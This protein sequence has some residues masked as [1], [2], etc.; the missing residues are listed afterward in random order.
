M[1][2]MLRRAGAML[3]S[4][5]VLSAVAGAGRAAEPSAKKPEPTTGKPNGGKAQ[6]TPDFSATTLALLRDSLASLDKGLPAGS[7]LRME[8][9]DKRLADRVAAAAPSSED[10]AAVQAEVARL[11]VRALGVDE[12]VYAV[13]PR[14]GTVHWYESFGYYCDSQ[15]PV[16]PETGG[17]LV[18]LDLRTGQTKEILAD[19]QGIFRDPCVSYD[20]SKILFSYRPAGRG[21]FHL[22]EANADGTG[23]RQLTDG[24]YDDIEPTYLPD[25]GIMFCS[26]RCRR[27]VPCLNAPVAILYRCDGDGRDIQP[28]SANVETENS[29]WPMPDGRIIYM[30]WEYVDRSRVTFHNL[31]TVNPDGTQHMVYWGN[32]GQPDVMNDPK[33]IPGTDQVICIA[34]NHAGA[35]HAGGVLI[36]DALGGPDAYSSL[37]FIPVPYQKL[38]QGHPLYRDPYPLSRDVFLVAVGDRVVVMDDTGRELVMERLPA[39]APASR[40]RQLW[41]HEPRPLAPRAREP[42]LA[43]RAQDRGATG[44]FL[45]VNVLQGRNMRGVRPGEIRMLLVLEVLPK[46]TD[47]DGHTEPL[48]HTGTF[49]LERI[50]GMVPVEPDGSAYFEA[51]AMR[52]L[53]F[54]ALDERGLSVQRMMS[55]TSLMPGETMSCVGCHEPR[56]R[57]SSGGPPPMALSKPPAQIQPIAGVPQIFDFGRDIQPV[58]NRHCV[59]CHNDEKRA[60]DLVLNDDHTIAFNQA[61]LMLRARKLFIDGNDG[62]NSGLPPRAVGSSASRILTMIDGSH[63]GVKLT[64]REQQWMRLWIDSACLYA[65]TYAALNTTPGYADCWGPDQVD[66]IVIKSRCA[67]CHKDGLMPPKWSPGLVDHREG[68]GA[69]FNLS[70]PERSLMLRAPLAKSAG[71]LGLCK[72]RVAVKYGDVAWGWKPDDFPQKLTKLKEG[73][74]ADVFQDT[75]D[76][77][78]QKLLADIRKLKAAIEP[79]RYD[80]PGFKGTARYVRE[81]KRHGVLP[82][83]FDPAKDPV[84][85]YET[86]ERYFRSFWYRAPD[87]AAAKEEHR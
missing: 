61:Y 80:Q 17:K 65:G 71:G 60:G 8:I 20:A 53:F 19:P 74:G 48:A 63:E 39:T 25:G 73:E 4:A 36:L 34:H 54:V 32:N 51:P 12:I 85:V 57:T 28:V 9:Q 56:Q 3:A 68:F 30:R 78:Y 27:W 75:K 82:A 16:Y 79:Q 72:K 70:L 38:P 64:P 77:D 37:R 45:L 50:L 66:K 76:P 41:I 67:E 58:L 87:E 24:E 49:F 35:D 26:A 33:P 7:P 43:P 13:R 1:M 21:T 14:T 10:F 59:S 2:P 22:Y 18:R 55:F 6:Q 69:R 62:V 44:T 46:P 31:W 42:V 81:M 5:F 29:P 83:T 40:R 11:R 52:P 86:D 23:L 84:N 47:H 15:R